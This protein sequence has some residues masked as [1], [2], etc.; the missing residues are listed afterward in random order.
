MF[1]CWQHKTRRRATYLG[2]GKRGDIAWYASLLHAYCVP[3]RKAPRQR[4]VAYLGSFLESDNIQEHA[5]FWKRL[6][7]RLGSLDIS[8][9]DHVKAVEGVARKIP[10]PSARDMQ[11]AKQRAVMDRLGQSVAAASA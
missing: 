7:A 8:R 4:F 5:A 1:V 11:A 2:R 10:R 3:G 9:A 6:D